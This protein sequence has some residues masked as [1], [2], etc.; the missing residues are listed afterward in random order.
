MSKLADMM[1][2]FAAKWGPKGEPDRA[3]FLEELAAMVTGVRNHDRQ[4]IEQR[5]EELRVEMTGQE[6]PTG[7]SE[8]EAM[9]REMT[10]DRVHTDEG[11]GPVCSLCS[12]LAKPRGQVDHDPSC[13]TTRARKLLKDLGGT[14]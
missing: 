6:K 4:R 13:L 7:I 14:P 8:F 1:N 11:D 3:A 12:G 9:L 2:V 5:I 10:V